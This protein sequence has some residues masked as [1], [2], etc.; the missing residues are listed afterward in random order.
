MGRPRTLVIV[1][2][3]GAGGRLELL[4]RSRAK[5]A[6][7]FAGT[8]R[9]IDFPLS[10]CLHAGLTDVWVIE[11]V[12]PVSLTDHLTNGRPW[13][14]DRTHGGLLVLGPRLGE[15]PEGWHKGTADS[16]WRYAGLIRDWQP[17]AVVVMSSDAVYRLD[18]AEVVDAHLGSG[19]LVTMVTTPVPPGEDASRFGVVTVNRRQRIVGYAY[20]PEQPQSDLVTT[21]VFVF[22]P[23]A[24][25]ERLEA[26]SHG[27]DPEEGLGDIGDALLPQLADERAALDWRFDGYWR[28]VG[29]VDA[30]WRAHQDLLGTDPP[31]VLDDARWPIYTRATWRAAARIDRAATVADSLVAPGARVFGEVTGSVIGPGAVVEEGAVVRDSVLLEGCRVASGATVVRTIADAGARIGTGATVGGDRTDGSGRPA[32]TLVGSGEDVP[33]GAALT[34]GSRFPADDD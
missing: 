32:I 11:Q 7:P 2:A 28:D 4:T 18:Y 33:K 15:G 3:G 34:A 21:E 23:R 31:L 14:L 24:L 17:A 19:G 12:N 20:K 13:D 1:L 30:Y 6:V 22:D 9:L 29:T 27:A 26:L 16:L 25:T 10:N 5:P 8:H